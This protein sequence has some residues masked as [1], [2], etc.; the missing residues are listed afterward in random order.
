MSTAIA[1]LHR[2]SPSLSA[3]SAQSQTSPPIS[4]PRNKIL[5]YIQ[6]VFNQYFGEHRRLLFAIR[7]S[8]HELFHNTVAAVNA[9]E[10]DALLYSALPA[11]AC[12]LC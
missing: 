11:R 7:G 6:A 9:D 12:V 2:V 5:S 4:D 10:G 8:D 3:F 1:V